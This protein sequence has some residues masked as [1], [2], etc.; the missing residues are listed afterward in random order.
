MFTMAELSFSISSLWFMHGSKKIFCLL[1]LTMLA[2]HLSSPLPQGQWKPRTLKP[3]LLKF[4]VDQIVFVDSRN[5]YTGGVKAYL[6]LSVPLKGWHIREEF[7]F[8]AWSHHPAFAKG[9][10]P[11]NHCSL[12]CQ[13]LLGLP[14]CAGDCDS[15]LLGTWMFSTKPNR[16]LVIVTLGWTAVSFCKKSCK[17][18]LKWL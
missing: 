1:P 7:F 12:S 5:P 4:Q 11:G 3:Q 13:S 16:Y 8:L 10:M 18:A 2:V 14:E 15:C 17:S 9:R 6:F